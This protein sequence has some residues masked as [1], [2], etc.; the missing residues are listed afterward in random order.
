MFVG[1]HVGDQAGN[2]DSGT[3]VGAHERHV[4]VLGGLV[5]K[6]RRKA[7]GGDGEGRKP[8]LWGGSDPRAD[9]CAMAF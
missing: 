3:V 5:V 4:R 7:D 1:K 6:N 2:N 9:G 8:V